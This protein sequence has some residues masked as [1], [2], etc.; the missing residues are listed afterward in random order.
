MSQNMNASCPTFC[1]RTQYD[2]DQQKLWCPI[3]QEPRL[4]SKGQVLGR[5]TD[6]MKVVTGGSMRV[7]NPYTIEG[8]RSLPDQNFRQVNQINQDLAGPLCYGWNANCG[9]PK[10]QKA[11]L[12]EGYCGRT[13]RDVME[14]GM[15]QI[16]Y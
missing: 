12:K 13:S 10:G 11:P 15:R 16:P 14:S 2:N 6:L 9:M 3:A 5:S 7:F 1:W 8:Y 4:D